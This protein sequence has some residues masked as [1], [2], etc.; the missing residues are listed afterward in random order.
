MRSAPHPHGELAPLAPARRA[1]GLALGWGIYALCGPGVLW[2]NGSPLAFAGVA[3]WGL[4]ARRPGRHAFVLE[5]LASALALGGQMWWIGY[6]FPLALAYVVPGFGVY[7]ACMGLLLRRLSRGWR[8]AIALPMAWMGV[9]TLRALL[10]PPVGLAWLSLGHHLSHLPWIAGSARVFGVV[11]LGYALGALAGLAVELVE[12]ARKGRGAPCARGLALGLGPLLL[13]V[14]L[15][16]LVPAPATVAGPR[17]LLVQPAFEQKRK[18]SSGT[19]A[20][21]FQE[22]ALLTRRGLAQERAAGRPEPD[23]VCWG[24]TMLCVMLAA[25]DLHDAAVAGLEVDPWLGLEA[26]ELPAL[27]RARERHEREWVEGLL[28][29]RRVEGG[30]RSP[31]SDPIVPEGSSFLAGA[32]LL[33][34][35]DG[36][37]R[38][39]NA[40]GL[41]DRD[42]RRAGLAAKKNL[43]P[44]GETMLGLERSEAVRRYIHEVSGYVPDFLAAERTGVLELSARDGRRHRIGATVCFDNAFPS[45]YTEPLR[46]GPLDF[47]LIVS[48]EAWYL[49]SCEMDQ[50]LAFSRI[51]ALA[52]ARSFVRATNAGITCAF[53][54]DGRELGRLVVDG[55]DRLVPGT[56]VVEVPVPDPAGAGAAALTPFVRWESAWYAAALLLPL[57]LA[58]FASARTVTARSPEVMPEPPEG[59]GSLA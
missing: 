12:G 51:A 18:Q 30:G 17:L 48:N 39:M 34:A 54:P 16:A 21:L 23:L 58:L 38:R 46:E 29:G 44:G 31:R 40:V 45:S 14:L 24:E 42:G 26:A 28:F 25:E 19:P 50:M 57:A 47:H 10:P 11:G 41:W 59:P 7:G 36:R 32:E 56:W 6:V 37:L 8:P 35:H 9:E 52:T 27:A 33:V 13:A 3:L 49:D 1:L 43:V 53:G 2:G 20:E 55:R 5:L 22:Q 4:V 15:A